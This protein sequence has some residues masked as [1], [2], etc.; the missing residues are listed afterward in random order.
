MLPLLD[1]FCP[2]ITSTFVFVSD[3]AI[4]FLSK[5][6]THGIKR[7]RKIFLRLTLNY[8][9]DI[10][11]ACYGSHFYNL[12]FPARIKR[13]LECSKTIILQILSLFLFQ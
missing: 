5:K 10:L 11:I 4:K 7:S 12:P 8:S 2:V 1:S 13:L 6:W 3:Y 9:Q